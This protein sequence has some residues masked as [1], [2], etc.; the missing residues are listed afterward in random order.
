MKRENITIKKMS[1]LLPELTKLSFTVK[2]LY[3]IHSKSV[4]R[5]ILV[6]HR[7]SSLKNT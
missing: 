5:V 6:F 4:S 7:I 3:E 2:G 1:G